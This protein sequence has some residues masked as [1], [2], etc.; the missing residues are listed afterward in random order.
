MDLIVH[1]IQNDYGTAGKHRTQQEAQHG[2]LT[3]AGSGLLGGHHGGIYDAH[4]GAVYHGGDLLRK[5]SGNGVGQKLCLLRAC[6]GDLYREDL[7][8]IHGAGADHFLELVIAIAHTGLLD[9]IVQRRAGV[10]N[11]NIGI[12]QA[13]GC[14]QVGCRNAQLAACH[15]NIRAV[16]IQQGVCLICRGDQQLGIAKGQAG[17]Y[18]RRQHNGHDM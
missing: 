6:A 2:I 14:R 13:F 3:G 4:G 15:G 1:Q 17:A 8:R 5:H 12:H 16:D 18:N 10:Q 9:D 11:N 7:R